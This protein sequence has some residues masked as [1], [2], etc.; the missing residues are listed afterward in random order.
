MERQDKDLAYLLRFENIAWFDGETV[1]ILDRRVYPW[2]E[3]HVVCRTPEEVA[4]AIKDMVTQS[5][6]PYFAAAM[7]MVLA[8]SIAQRENLDILDYG[9]RA[10]Y[11]LSH[12]RPTTV[13]RM[14]AVTNSSLKAIEI[15]LGEGSDPLQAA[16]DNAIEGINA[17]YASTKKTAHHLVNLFPNQ[18]TVMTQC[19]AETILGLM[20]LEIRNQNKKIDFICPETR[21][22]LQGGR[23]TSSVLSDMGH[24]VHV[25]TDNMPGYILKN[26]KVDVFTSAADVISMDGHIVNKIGTFQ[27]ALAAN[28]W[29]IPYYVTGTPNPA[30]PTIDTVKIEERDHSQVT[31]LFGT[32]FV[33][34]AVKAYYPAFDV[35]PP[36][37]CSGVVTTK[38]VFSA[39]D[40]KQHFG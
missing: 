28:Y 33:K 26:K 18:G 34:P 16:F 2:K 24:S 22:Y 32:T 17:R 30:H 15:A 40:L 31:T 8:V 36:H 5:G 14:E 7:G 27:I 10:A 12:P 3:E 29:G 19:Y 9:R 4:Q 35:T 11:T 37:L 21:P 1:K 38:G 13:A 6:G 23:L 25:I 39:F 20:C